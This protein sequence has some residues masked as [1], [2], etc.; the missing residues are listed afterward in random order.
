MV[1]I[2]DSASHRSSL[3]KPESMTAK[4]SSM[5]TLLSAMLVDR[6]TLMVPSEAGSKTRCWSSC[7]IVECKGRI[8]ILCFSSILESSSSSNEVA[9]LISSQPGRKQRMLPFR[10]ASISALL[11]Y[12]ANLATSFTMESSASRS[13]ALVFVAM[14]ELKGIAAVRFVPPMA[15]C[16]K[17]TAR[18]NVSILEEEA[19]IMDVLVVEGYSSSNSFSE[20]ESESSSES[21]PNKSPAS[22][23][24]ERVSSCTAADSSDS[25][26]SNSARSF[27]SWYRK[28]G[29]ARPCM[30]PGKIPPVAFE[31][32]MS[33]K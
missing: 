13:W 33:S 19:G 30:L 18:F 25:A 11:R 20:S 27:S 14:P 2:A 8:F 12:H 17:E 31:S 1:D 7:G 32:D 28:S 16:L 26:S 21:L 9:S 3:T 29:A 24:S 10:P 5:V 22:S 4:T 6:I 15:P 23:A